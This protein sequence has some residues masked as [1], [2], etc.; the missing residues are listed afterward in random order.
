MLRKAAALSNDPRDFM[1]LGQAQ[2]ALYRWADAAESLQQALSIGGLERPGRVHMQVGTAY[3]NVKRFSRA[4]QA[5]KEAGAFEGTR[6]KAAQW[7]RFID[8]E[9]ARERALHGG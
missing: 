6:D 2:L 8:A 7:V 4:R 9:V 1:Y 3:Y 5:F